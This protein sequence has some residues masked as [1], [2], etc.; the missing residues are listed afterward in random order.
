MALVGVVMAYQ[1][2]LNR[3]SLSV[4]EPGRTVR[5]CAERVSSLSG[6]S[7]PSLAWRGLRRG[8]RPAFQ[9]AEDELRTDTGSA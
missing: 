1:T 3:A 5:R 2:A 8:S 9:R 6:S 4:A 7:P